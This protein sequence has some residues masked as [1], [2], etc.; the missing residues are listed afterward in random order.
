MRLRYYIILAAIPLLS[1]G[2]RRDPY[3]DTYIEALNAE[4]R[5]LEDH[6]YDLEYEV[7]ARND[8]IRNLQDRLARNT[9]PAGRTTSGGSSQLDNGQ[10][11]KANGATP[12]TPG[13]ND[14][15]GDM[16]ITPPDF[17]LTPPTIDEGT[18]AGPD[19]LK[20]GVRP[21]SPAQIKK[22]NF[23]QP[24]PYQPPRDQRVTHLVINPVLSGGHNFDQ[25][26][27]PDGIAVVFQPR[28]LGDKFVD[29]AADVSI[30]AVDPELPQ[31]ESVLSQWD[32]SAHEIYHR[33]K[34][35]PAAERG[36]HLKLPWRDKTPK[37]DKVDVYV[38]YI[39]DDG[40][41]METRATLGMKRRPKFSKRWTPRP[42]G[43]PPR[44]PVTGVTS[45]K[46][47]TARTDAAMSGSGQPANPT[48][49][50][51]LNSIMNR[52]QRF[53]SSFP[54][55][56]ANAP[57]AIPVQGPA[58]PPAATAAPAPPAK[59]VT[60]RKPAWTPYRN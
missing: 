5:L 7:K 4:K 19:V 9:S 49:R 27:G 11:D 39:S 52:L 6:A 57:A 16:K 18:P 31:E 60:P 24:E 23:Q 21:N 25:V 30:A 42:A 34:I 2:C 51:R 59:A 32:F 46:M 58:I 56:P 8:K 29:Q 44:Q 47:E 48:T 14:D 10:L 37:G 13:G 43:N 45:E 20:T 35:E 36:I 15:G 22:I 54:A 50:D 33:T 38:R 1:T 12:A 3:L 40:R 53:N 28:N 26:A 41:T 55:A 17:D